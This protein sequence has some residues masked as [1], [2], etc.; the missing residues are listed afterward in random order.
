MLFPD[1]P[2]DTSA[3]S[4]MRL[5]AVRR[6]WKWTRRQKVLRQNRAERLTVLVLPIWIAGLRVGWL[7]YWRGRGERTANRNGRWRVKGEQ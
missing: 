4:G 1:P 3:P 5:T 6:Q 7:F 2:H